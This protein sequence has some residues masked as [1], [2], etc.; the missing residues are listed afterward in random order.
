MTIGGREVVAGVVSFG[1]HKECTHPD[2]VDVF[3]RVDAFAA[4]IGEQMDA[5]EEPDVAD[6]GA[7]G[8]QGAP[9]ST[10]AWVVLVLL[11]VAAPRRRRVL[12]RY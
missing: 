7:G 6:P 2:T 11:A 5:L 3:V 10:S 8:C 4:W 1:T 12:S 9:G